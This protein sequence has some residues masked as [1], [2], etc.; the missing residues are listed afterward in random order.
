MGEGRKPG[1]SFTHGDAVVQHVGRNLSALATTVEPPLFATHHCAML[2]A[3]DRDQILD[4]LRDH[5]PD[6]RRHGVVRAALFGSTARGEAQ[7]DS[8]IDILVELD[9][10]APIDLLAYVGIVQF[11]EDLFPT[12]V[13]VANRAALRPLVRPSVERDAVYA[14]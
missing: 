1:P 8:D 10:E 5:A 6:L 7:P 12:A 4:R 9:P 13:D 14:F 3:M 11:I 2:T